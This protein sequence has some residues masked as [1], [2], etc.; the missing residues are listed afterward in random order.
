MT[1]YYE[2]AE[3]EAIAAFSARLAAACASI[4]H[5]SAAGA[6]D[7]SAERAARAAA[8]AER[9]AAEAERA[10]RSARAAHDTDAAS[11]A[12]AERAAKEAAREAKRT[13]MTVFRAATAPLRLAHLAAHGDDST[14][15]PMPGASLERWQSQEERRG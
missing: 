6:L 2:W 7:A 13:A 9:H 5:H 3:R 11:V 14:P 8:A 12:V 15:A 4:E 10:L 1:S